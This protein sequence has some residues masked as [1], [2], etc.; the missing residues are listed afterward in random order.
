MQGARGREGGW[1]A[2]ARP[3]AGAFALSVVLTLEMESQLDIECCLE[4]DDN[5]TVSTEHSPAS[6]MV[7]LFLSPLISPF[8]HTIPLLI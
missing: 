6:T 2:C 7:C 4:S 3:A 5:Y 8:L 1:Y